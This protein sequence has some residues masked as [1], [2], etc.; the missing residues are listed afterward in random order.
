MACTRSCVRTLRICNNNL[1]RS[2]PSAV[3]QW[4]YLIH[5]L[6]K[7]AVIRPNPNDRTFIF[8]ISTMC[9]TCELI[10]LRDPQLI[11]LA[12]FCS[13]LN[14]SFFPFF[15]SSHQILSFLFHSSF[16]PF[17]ISSVF[18]FLPLV[19][20]FFHIFFSSFRSFLLFFL[21][22]SLS[23]FPFFFSSFQLTAYPSFLFIP[24]FL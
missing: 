15:Y 1:S 3:A 11:L 7:Y 19:S 17:F 14:P 5:C 20:S 21:P 12:I 6:S 8:A 9:G 23:L 2:I 10:A 22:P 24:I 13:M 4:G 16:F 18:S